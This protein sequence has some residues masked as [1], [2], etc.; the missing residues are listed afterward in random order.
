MLYGH[1]APG[2][3][4]DFLVVRMRRF[5]WRQATASRAS[6]EA[7]RRSSL[8]RIWAGK[9]FMAVPDAARREIEEAVWAC[10]PGMTVHHQRLKRLEDLMLDTGAVQSFGSARRGHE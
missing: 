2:A 4:D 7:Q 6:R 10:R 9:S 1:V 3:V 8:L 5:S